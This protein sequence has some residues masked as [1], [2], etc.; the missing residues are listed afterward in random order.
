MAKKRGQVTLTRRREPVSSSDQQIN[1]S[2]NQQVNKSTSQQK[3]RL[4]VYVNK[5]TQHQLKLAQL[6]IGQ[7]T[8]ATGYLVTLTNLTEIA[9]QMNGV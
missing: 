2:T 1:K 9:L 7:L 5:D 3:E 6:Q 8:G 4:T